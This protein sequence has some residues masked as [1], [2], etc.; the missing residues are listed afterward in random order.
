MRDTV[1]PYEHNP[2]QHPPEQP[3][4]VEGEFEF[5]RLF[6]VLVSAVSFMGLLAVTMEAIYT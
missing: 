6:A 4:G 5:G 2:M 3:T 1:D